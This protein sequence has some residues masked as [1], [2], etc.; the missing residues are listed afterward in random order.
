VLM[1]FNGI[2]A[3]RYASFYRSG[4]V[5]ELETLARNATRIMTAIALVPF[6]AIMTFGEFILMQFGEQYGNA[7]PVLRIIAIAQFLNVLAGPVLNILN[8]SGHQR[9]VM[10]ITAVSGFGVLLVSFPVYAA[11]GLEGI[12]CVIAGGIILNNLLAVLTIKARLGFIPIR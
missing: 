6:V 11:Y 7:L 10:R 4:Q 5:A 12:A 3:P 8:M 2:F 1:I 9:D